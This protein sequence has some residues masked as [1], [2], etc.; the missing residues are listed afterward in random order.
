MPA[1]ESLKTDLLTLNPK[2]FY[3]KHIVKSHNWYFS[4][5]LQIPA[6]ELVDRMDFFKEIV[7][8]NLEINFHSLQIVGSAKTGYSL[9]PK[10]VLHPFH[11]E[12]PGTPASD[13]DI[14][15]VSQKLYE[16]YWNL[17]RHVKGIQYKRYYN[18]LTASIFRGYINDKDL[19]EIKGISREWDDLVRPINVELQDQLGFV[20]P[21]TYRVYRSWDDLEDYQLGG[22]A[23]A[24]KALEEC[25]D[26]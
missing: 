1:Q 7:S 16:K 12:I 21:I 4:N 25:K 19:A 11:D 8:S 15:I 13:I 6:D 24:R 20:H 26:V 17:L 9:S 18:N 2:D 14:A 10:K 5:Y 23:K 22:I 3:M